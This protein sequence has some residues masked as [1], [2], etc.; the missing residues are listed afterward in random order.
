[1]K[2]PLPARSALRDGLLLLCLCG[3]LSFS[4]C[5]PFE[6]KFA[7]DRD[8]HDP[9]QPLSGSWKGTWQSDLD[10]TQGAA[11][12]VVETASAS[13]C[14]AWLEM[15]G[16]R[17]VVASWICLPDLPVR[18]LA[19]G[20]EQF[21]VKVPIEGIPRENVWAVAMTIDGQLAGRSLTLRFRTNDAIQ[22]LDAG[23]ISL[24]P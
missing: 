12:L 17:N 1:M 3:M 6:A 8:L 13:T 19:D 24:T 18:R 10:H 16:Y 11:R 22:Q 23:T 15:S 14:N 9:T 7:A 4:G 20:T 5:V 21:S 2:R